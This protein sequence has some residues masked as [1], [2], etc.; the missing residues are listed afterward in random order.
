MRF[1]LPV[2]ASGTSINDAFPDVI[3]RGRSGLSSLMT[4]AISDWCTST[5]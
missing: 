2:L 5:R 1:V 3:E 4:W